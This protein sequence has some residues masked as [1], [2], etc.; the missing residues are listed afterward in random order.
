MPSAAQSTSKPRASAGA[1]P[2]E[3]ELT[4]A[5]DQLGSFDFETRTSAARTVR[6]ATPAMAAPAL[7]R[8]VAVAQGRV[9]P[10]PRAGAADGIDRRRRAAHARARRGSQ[11]PAAH[12]RVS[13]VGASS[14]SG[15]PDD[16]PR[17]A[18]AR[19]VGVRAAGAHASASP[20]TARM[21]A[22][23]RRSCRSSCAAR[24]CFAAR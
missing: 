11:R 4:A 23:A 20:R 6:R 2:T 21:R 22:R 1:A 15:R 18:S 17:R 8:A 7:E 3:A 16:A 10:V 19:A 5:I 24:I 13:V 14:G 12:G 9:R